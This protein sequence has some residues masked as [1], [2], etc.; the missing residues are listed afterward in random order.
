MRVPNERVRMETGR[1]FG[2]L[3]QELGGFAYNV[4]GGNLS[5][6]IFIVT[7]LNVYG[8]DSIAGKEKD[9]DSPK[10]LLPMSLNTKLLEIQK[11]KMRNK[12]NEYPLGDVPSITTTTML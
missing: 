8:R 5:G 11:R 9:G 3:S 6:D 12:F 10:R 1:Y 7:A 2:S 4:D